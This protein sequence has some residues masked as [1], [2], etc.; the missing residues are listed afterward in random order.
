MTN[1]NL[2]LN[3]LKNLLSEFDRKIVIE[4]G[5]IIG[6]KPRSQLSILSK[7]ILISE[8][9]RSLETSISDLR[10]LKIADSAIYVEKDQG[11]FKLT[12]SEKEE[13]NDLPE[14]LDAG[15]QVEVEKQAEEQV[16][17]QAEEQ[18]DVESTQ[19]FK[20]IEKETDEPKPEQKQP[21]LDID[22]G[23]FKNILTTLISTSI[24]IVL[25]EVK[26]QLKIHIKDAID[27]LLE[28][29]NFVANSKESIETPSQNEIKKEVKCESDSESPQQIQN[30]PQDIPKKRGRP[31]KKA[32]QQ[33]TP[34]LT[35]VQPDS[36]QPP[37]RK[38]G[39]PPKK[40]Q[41]NS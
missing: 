32:A 22:T 6:L 10:I 12:H 15:K 26:K 16:E 41:E 36:S 25:Q 7:E 37:K 34:P 4:F 14:N 9:L 33:P 31:S 38:R 19:E 3:E 28:E 1:L 2:D 29:A 27:E 20:Q 35:Q 40:L 21:L 17:E 23:K 24:D 18:D 30:I 5:S 13:L 39:R 8:I 11:L